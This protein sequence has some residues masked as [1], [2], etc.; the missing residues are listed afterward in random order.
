GSVPQWISERKGAEKGTFVG[1]W[2]EMP[3]AL[4]GATFKGRLLHTAHEGAWSPDRVETEVDTT[5]M[6]EKAAESD[7]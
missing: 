1:R 3:T 5:D 2:P 6:R 4:E 7:R